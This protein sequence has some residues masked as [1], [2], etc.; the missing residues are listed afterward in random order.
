MA[1]KL[2]LININIK[3]FY[4]PP[5]LLDLNFVVTTLLIGNIHG[6][7]NEGRADTKPKKDTFAILTVTVSDPT[8][9]QL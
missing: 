4:T 9:L 5:L 8:A 1:L 6:K 2:C 3:P 7:L